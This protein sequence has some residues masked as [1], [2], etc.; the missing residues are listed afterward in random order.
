MIIRFPYG[1]SEMIHDFSKEN[2]VSVLQSRIHS[3]SPS[4]C[5]ETLVENAIENPIGSPKLSELAK[6]KRNVVIIASDHTRPVP[7]RWIIPSMLREIRKGNPDA[8]ITILIATGCHRNTTKEELVEKFGKEITDR[9]TIVIHDCDDKGNLTNLGTLPSGGI[10]K[11]NSL[12]ANADLLLAE[13][14]IEPHFFAGFS[15]GRKSVLPGIAG[16]STVLAN[17]C[18]EFVN[19]P[20]ARTGVLNDN[21]IHRDMLWA[22]KKAKLAYIVNVVLNES[23]EVIW[24]VSGDLEKAHQAGVDFLSSLCSVSPVFAD[25]VVSTNGGFPLDQNVY[26]AVKGMTAAEASVNKD[27]VIIMLAKSSDGIGGEHFYQQTSGDTSLEETMSQILSRDRGSTLPDQWQS[28][29]LTRILMRARV[30]YVSELDKNTVEKM[31]MHAAKSVEEALDIAKKLLNKKDPSI[32]IIPDG[33]SVI[34]RTERE[35]Q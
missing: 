16:R 29:V 6:G 22:A 28:Q 15:G 11:I 13:G 2:V 27:G 31:H 1:K 8:Q 23:K 30:V 20:F 3:Y 14:F 10:C 12:A 17:H 5:S 19:S 33:I 4:S 21:P 26:Q 34:V 25:V 32:T 24:A 35:K 7:S 18:A 9:E